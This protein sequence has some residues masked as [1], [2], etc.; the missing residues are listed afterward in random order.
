MTTKWNTAIFTSSFT[1]LDCIVTSMKSRFFTTLD[2]QWLD[3]DEAPRHFP[4]PQLHQKKV[5]LIGWQSVNGLIHYIFLKSGETITVEK[6]CQEINEMYKEV[7][8]Q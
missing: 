4:N 2:T 3:A 7:R 1:F 8:Q 6:H 5:M